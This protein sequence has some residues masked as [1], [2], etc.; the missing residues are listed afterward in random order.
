[1]EALENILFSPYSTKFV[2][3]VVFQALGVYFTLYYLMPKY[4]ETAKY[5]K[6]LVAVFLTIIVTAA[7]IITGY[8]LTAYWSSLSFESLFGDTTFSRLFVTNSLPSTVASMTLAMSI[9]LAKNWISSQKRQ[10][11][12]EREKIETELKFLKS[13]FNPH[14][15]FNTI[16][17]IFVLIHKNPN[18]ASDSLAKFSD[19]L[20]YQL[21]ECNEPK[22]PLQREM[23]YLSNF[24]ELGRLRLDEDIDVKITIGEMDNSDFEIAPFI[25]MPFLENA[26]K[27]VS[28]VKRNK[29]W[30]H[31]AMQQKGYGIEMNIT[32]STLPT[33]SKSMLEVQENGGI[34]LANVRRR[35]DLLYPNSYDLNIFK[36]D[37]SYTVSL[38]LQLSSLAGNVIPTTVPTSILQ[39]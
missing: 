32:N 39:S 15:L 21:Y 29:N 13:Q 10:Q 6:F 3:Y 18:M 33:E 22:I 26:F 16:N 23:E 36:K 24:I 12:L 30:L 11:L 14:F 5:V 19:L 7:L 1:M 4:L 35:L 17:S 2:F 28:Q 31:I 9:K 25:L 27:H 34:G 20:R 37:R 38:R 8:Y